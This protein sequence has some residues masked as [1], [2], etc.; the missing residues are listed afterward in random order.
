MVSFSEYH[1][2]YCRQDIEWDNTL[3]I[4][5]EKN[6]G[7]SDVFFYDKEPDDQN[8]VLII[9][10]RCS[11]CGKETGLSMDN[12]NTN[13][14]DIVTLSVLNKLL[15]RIG[16]AWIIETHE[17]LKYDMGGNNPGWITGSP[18]YN[19]YICKNYVEQCLKNL[20]EIQEL[21][22]IIPCLILMHMR[23]SSHRI[24]MI[25][26]AV[27]VICCHQIQQQKH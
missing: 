25:I 26:E 17:Q 21:T 1:G 22:D 15:H 19:T 6:L 18:W 23:N 7:V 12:M 20:L 16:M 2:V 8:D 9:G 27:V 13:Y 5:F 11:N 3:T 4:H 10:I 14:K 24:L